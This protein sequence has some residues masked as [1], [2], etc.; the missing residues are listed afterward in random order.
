[1]NILP[2]KETIDMENAFTADRYGKGDSDYINCPMTREEY[3]L[4]YNELILL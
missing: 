2:T 3:E 4:F 1:M